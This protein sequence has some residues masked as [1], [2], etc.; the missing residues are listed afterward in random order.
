MY[1]YI[2]IYIYTQNI[3]LL[4]QAPI[5]RQAASTSSRWPPARPLSSLVWSS[6]VL[7]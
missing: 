2:Y 6:L 7:V 1:V 5:G 4:A 3:A